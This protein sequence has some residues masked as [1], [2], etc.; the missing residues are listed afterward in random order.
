MALNTKKVEPLLKALRLSI[1]F[2]Q[3]TDRWWCVDHADYFCG[4]ATVRRWRPFVRRRR[5]TSRPPF[6]DIRSRKPWT[7][8]RLTLLGWK[9]RFDTA[10]SFLQGHHWRLQ[11]PSFCVA[12]SDSRERQASGNL[13]RLS[14]KLQRKTRSEAAPLRI[15]PQFFRSSAHA[16]AHASCNS[17]PSCTRKRPRCR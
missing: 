8:A 7:R 5:R 9:V 16:E 14:R 15:F 2:V 17:M 10:N 6:V 13:P 12:A 1:A 11:G 3:R 4:R